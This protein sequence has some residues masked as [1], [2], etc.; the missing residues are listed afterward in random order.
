MVMIE[1]L[2]YGGGRAFRAADHGVD[3]TAVDAA[4]DRGA[5]LGDL[6]SADEEERAG[7]TTPGSRRWFRRDDRRAG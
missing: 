7:V 6:P 4:E 5:D 1:K 3:L 2:R